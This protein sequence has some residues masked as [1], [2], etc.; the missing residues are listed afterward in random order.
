M[1]VPAALRNHLCPERP[2]V[3]CRNPEPDKYATAR[4]AEMTGDLTKVLPGQDKTK[5]VSEQ[6]KARKAAGL[7]LDGAQT[8]RRLIKLLSTCA[9]NA[10]QEKLTGPPAGH[11]TVNFLAEPPKRNRKK[12]ECA[13]LEYCRLARSCVAACHDQALSRVLQVHSVRYT[14]HGTRGR[15]AP[16]AQRCNSASPRTRCA[17]TARTLGDD[18]V[19]R[20][21]LVQAQLRR[22]RP[23][24]PRHRPGAEQAA[25]AVTGGQGSRGHRARRRRGGGVGAVDARGHS[26]SRAPSGWTRQRRRD[27]GWGRLAWQD[28]Q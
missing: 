28:W 25:A 12:Q 24:H 2:S 11:P 20:I 19:T 16:A 14:S 15:Y 5:P 27:R 6:R 21:A 4:C 17:H 3:A 13:P 1:L 22:A 26:S 18:G 23:R 8:K 10:H 9:E 7:G